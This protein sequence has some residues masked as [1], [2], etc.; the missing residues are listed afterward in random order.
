MALCIWSK[1]RIFIR[2]G[3]ELKE[4][5]HGIKNTGRNSLN[6][7]SGNI[8]VFNRL[9]RPTAALTAYFY[10]R[11]GVHV[12]E[13]TVSTGISGTKNIPPLALLYHGDVALEGLQYF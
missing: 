12:P 5:S 10:C 1:W 6:F 8:T 13:L 11:P 4:D 3:E 9:C 2:N 7:Q